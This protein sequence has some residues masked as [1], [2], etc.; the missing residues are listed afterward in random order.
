MESSVRTHSGL[1]TSDPQAVTHLRKIHLLRWTLVFFALCNV[2]AHVYATPGA[3]PITTWWIDV[4]IA[5][6]SLIAVIY[7]FG[8]R[9]FYWPPLLFTAYTLIMY[10]LSGAV[11]MG[12]IDPTPLVGH[13][14]FLHYSFGRGFSVISWL[15]LL[16]VGWVILKLDP[17]SQVN[18]LLS[19]S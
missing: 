3:T 11:A 7:L 8:L 12:A 19:R 9:M 18:D 4:E 14:Q 10:F 5:T 13:L 17:G 1:S 6:Y 16:I 15:Y 2:A